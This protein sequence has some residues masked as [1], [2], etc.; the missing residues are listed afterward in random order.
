MGSCLGS[1]RGGGGG[2]ACLSA[3][4]AACLRACVARLLAAANVLG[5]CAHAN[6]RSPVCVRVC[7]ASSLLRANRLPHCTQQKARASRG[8]CVDACW[9]R[10]PACV[11]RAPH[12]VH[13]NGFSP[14]C[15]RAWLSRAPRCANARPQC[16][17]GNGRS[18]GVCV[19]SCAVRLPSH[20]N[21]D[22]KKP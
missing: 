2:R 4:A 20:A 12:V 7:V 9:R 22:R 15:V 10:W 3:P 8:A 13:A 5:Q 18:S 14:V 6:G 19:R 17:H 1:V 11:K 21:I 16:G